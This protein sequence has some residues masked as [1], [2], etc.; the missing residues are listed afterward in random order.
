MLRGVAESIKRAK[1]GEKLSDEEQLRVRTFFLNHKLQMQHEASQPAP[2][3]PVQRPPAGT[4]VMGPGGQLM[5]SIGP[6]G[7]LGPNTPGALS[8][9]VGPGQMPQEAEA[10]ARMREGGV[11][12]A[13]V[14]GLMSRLFAPLKRSY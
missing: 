3:G 10:D 6:K 2:Q 4:P 9:K 14:R 7:S 1:A 8:F 11:D 13:A 12:P 5:P